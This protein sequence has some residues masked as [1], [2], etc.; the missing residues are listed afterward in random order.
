MKK[1]CFLI[2]DL[3]PLYH[4]NVCSEESRKLIEEHIETCKDCKSELEKYNKEFKGVNYMNKKA[5]IEE[6]KPINTIA[7]KWKRDKKIS[8]LAGTA[9]VSIIGCIFSVISYNS[10]GSYV[11]EDGMLV[12]S[13]GFIPLAYLFGLI[14]IIS[15]LAFGIMFIKKN[16][17][18]KK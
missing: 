15:M 10:A 12:E 1:H 11:D 2:R 5:N 14:A 13:F 17:K 6:A 7:K 8:F 3:L 4:D 9:L 16:F 18:H